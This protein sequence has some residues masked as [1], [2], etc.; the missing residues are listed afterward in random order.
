MAPGERSEWKTVNTIGDFRIQPI[1]V[2]RTPF[3]ESAGT[4]ILPSRA[5]GTRGEVLI[6]EP[7]RVGLRDLDGFERIWLIYWFHKAGPADLLVIPYLDTQQRG[8]FATRAP[9]RPCPIGISAVRLLHVREGSLDVADLDILDGTP[10]L[11]LK[12]YVPES[13]SHP[14]SKAGWFDESKSRRCLADN[15]FESQC[16]ITKPNKR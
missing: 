8:L 5:Q 11:D 13:D 4:P 16:R 12:P 10:L 9:A 3:Q 14:T 2:I 1:G 7:F 15:R 6:H